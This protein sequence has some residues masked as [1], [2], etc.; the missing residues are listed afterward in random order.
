MF[1]GLLGRSRQKQETPCNST[2]RRLRAGHP[3]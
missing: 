2:G 3:L 1:L